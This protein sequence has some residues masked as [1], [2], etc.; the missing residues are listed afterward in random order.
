MPR[1]AALLGPTKHPTNEGIERWCLLREFPA[2]FG[3]M[4]VNAPQR[5]E[6]AFLAI[7]ERR[8]GVTFPGALA[9]F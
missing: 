4:S 3:E 7:S 8:S 1:D 6:A 5:A 9:P 2:T